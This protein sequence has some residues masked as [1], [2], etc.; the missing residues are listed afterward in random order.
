MSGGGGGGGGEGQDKD[1]YALLWILGIFFVVSGL[2]WYFWGYYLKLAIIYLKRYEALAISFFVDN[3][4]VQKAVEGLSMATPD[5][6]DLYYID[7]ISTFIGSY[8]MYPI[9][10][11]LVVMAIIMFKGHATLRFTK[12]YSMETLA[13]QERKNW[14]QISP[15]VDIDL[16]EEDV[17]KGPWAMSMNPMEFARNNKLLKLEVIPDRKAAWKSEG[18]IKPTVIKEKAAKVFST[19]LGPLWTG[20]NNLPPHTKALY[21][22]FLARIEHD[23]EGCRGYLHKLSTASAKGTLDYSNTDV[24]L[25]KYGKSKA[26]ALCHSRHAYVST[27]MATI[28]ELARVDGVLASSDFLW[29]KP[30]DRKLWYI[31]NCVGRQVAISEVGG[32]F[33]HWIAEKEMGKPLSVPMIDEAVIGLEKAVANIIY[34]PE[35][36]EVIAPSPTN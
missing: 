13:Q 23:T 15:V 30:V 31:L 32:I 12:A 24:L 10:F 26:A 22:A 20:V 11:V 25:K 16:I 33:A 35:E 29:I 18:T 6:I 2:V 27:V 4:N 7:K 1:S 19:Q 3:E 14:P 34:I 8:M 17:D 9:C 21:A 36:G 28:L 5:N